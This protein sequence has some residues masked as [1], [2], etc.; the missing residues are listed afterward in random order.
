MI[1]YLAPLRPAV[2]LQAETASGM[3][4]VL[5]LPFI[6]IEDNKNVQYLE[7]TLTDAVRKK[8]KK[9]FVFQKLPQRQWQQVAQNNYFFRDDYATKSVAMNLGLLAKQDVVI[10]GGYRVTGK[11][12]LKIH[13]TVR[14][15][16]ISQKKVIAEFTEIGPADNRIFDTVNTIAAKI[17][18]KAKA[19]LPTKGEWQKK[20]LSVE[21]S[22]PFMSDFR[23]S[24]GA[25]GGFYLLDHSDNIEAKQPALSA[26]L[27]GNLPFLWSRLILGLEASYIQDTP[28][29]DKNPNIEGLN[30]VTSNYIL[31]ASLGPR[32]YLGSLAVWPRFGGGYLIQTISVTGDRTDEL[33]HSMPFARGGF[34][35][36][37]PL[38]ASLDLT[39]AVDSLAEFDAGSLTLLNMARLG[40]QFRL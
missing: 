40:V 25:G 6:N 18:D 4:K 28:I 13:T 34:V 23:L 14:I 32:F 24:L 20:G 12:E 30:I 2:Y 33:T 8:L 7:A 22:Q 35:L 9:L 16:D 11:Q 15:L 21:P 31:G 19:V 1:A 38:N 39:L 3:K 36:A 5:V 26:G 27:S 37:Y 17:S 29:A 10:A